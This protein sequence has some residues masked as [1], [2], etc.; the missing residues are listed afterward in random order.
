MSHN[1]TYELL[2]LPHLDSVPVDY[3][4]EGCQ[5][6]GTHRSGYCLRCHMQGIEVVDPWTADPLWMALHL[7][8][9]S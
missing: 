8:G 9:A 6:K 2:T 4:C 7:D 1:L 3:R 5:R